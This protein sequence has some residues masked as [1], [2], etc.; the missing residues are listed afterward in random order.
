MSAVMAGTAAAILSPGRSG[1]AQQGQ[2]LYGNGFGGPLLE[3][4]GKRLPR[5]VVFRFLPVLLPMSTLRVT[6]LYG[7]RRDPIHGFS[8]MHSGV[9]FAAPVGTPV[10]ATAA[11]RVL[12]VGMAGNYGLAVEVG[13][14]FG[15]STLY[16]HLA[17]A[18][19][20]V[21]QVVDRL[22]TIG[23]VGMT[24]RT[25]GP[26]LHFEIRQNGRAINPIEFLLRAYRLYNH[27]S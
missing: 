5:D 23:A 9:D 7:L 19:P 10:Y 2:T 26:H 22:Q 11:G 21:G 14:A 18:L 12:F 8:A 4:G 1:H 27:L 6:S 16:A 17:L 3:V 15:F 24:G 13:H 20:A 25:T